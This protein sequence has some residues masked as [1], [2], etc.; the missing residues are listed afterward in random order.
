MK[1]LISLFLIYFVPTAAF[2]TESY[3]DVIQRAQ[4]FALDQDRLQAMQILTKELKN[5]SSENKRAIDAVEKSL[6]EISTMLYTEKGQKLFEYAKSL[7]HES[8]QESM[9]KFQEAL[10]VEPNNILIQ[11]WI[12]RLSLKQGKCEDAAQSI[13]KGLDLDPYYQPAWLVKTQ[14]LI[15]LQRSEELLKEANELRKLETSYPIYYQV[16]M[17]QE[18]LNKKDFL[19]AENHLHKA[20][21]IDKGFPEIYFWKTQAL[22]KQDKDIKET[23]VKYIKSCKAMTKKDYAHYELEPRTCIEYKNF[24][25]EY[26]SVLDQ[27]GKRDL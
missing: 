3:K 24:E 8:S 10:A 27:E 23:V 2:A 7:F 6:D 21:Q 14:A 15:C 9:E 26:K 18:A 4:N 20:E 1:K 5:L 13:Q 25:A 17:A 19:L 12:A 22:E 16:L 11:T